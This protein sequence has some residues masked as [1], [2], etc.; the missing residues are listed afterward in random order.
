MVVSFYYLQLPIAMKVNR[1]ALRVIRERSGLSISELARQCGT[2]QP[3]L[4]NIETGRRSA[5]PA[6]LRELATVLK[7]PVLAL[8]A[9]PDEDSEAASSLPT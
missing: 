3:H 4:S 2:S 9:D 6:L 5:S 1:H 7:V 8:L